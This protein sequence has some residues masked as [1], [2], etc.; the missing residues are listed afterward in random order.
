MI[1]SLGFGELETL[2]VLW[3]G[4]DRCSPADSLARNGNR[5]NI[6]LFTDTA[7]PG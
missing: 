1:K 5:E 6:F 2:G 4:R 7:V 3:T